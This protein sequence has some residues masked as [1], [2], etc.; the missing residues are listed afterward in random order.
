M[1]GEPQFPSGLA[2]EP[3]QTVAVQRR[4]L[5]EAGG[6]GQI[7]SILKLALQSRTHCHPQST[8]GVLTPKGTE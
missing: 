8:H 7:G 1:L 6:G 4:M 5:G 2:A 3:T